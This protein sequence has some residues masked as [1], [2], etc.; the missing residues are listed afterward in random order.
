M[1][2]FRAKRTQI[3]CDNLTLTYDIKYIIFWRTNNKVILKENLKIVKLKTF[4][5]INRRIKYR[6]KEILPRHCYR[7]EM[8]S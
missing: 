7:E 6:M 5:A 8:E 2:V 1:H 3:Q 4:N